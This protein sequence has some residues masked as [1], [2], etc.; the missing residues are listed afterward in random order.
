MDV[1]GHQNERMQFIPAFAPVPIKRR[2]EE[3]SVRFNNEQSP[4]L[5]RRK[6]HEISSGRGEKPSRLQE[7]TSAAG[8]RT[9][10]RTLNWHEW[11]SC[12][13]RLFSCDGFRFGT[14]GLP[15]ASAV[16]ATDQA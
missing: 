6:R 14:N 11:N 16:G 13:S 15:A 2:Q 1:L 4:P 10:L 7:Q 8:S 9:S 5:P 3:G 12:P